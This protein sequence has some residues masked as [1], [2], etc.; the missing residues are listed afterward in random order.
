M[1]S[2]SANKQQATDGTMIIEN[3]LWLLF[4]RMIMIRVLRLGPVTRIAN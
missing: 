1:L 4:L 2:D 3:L